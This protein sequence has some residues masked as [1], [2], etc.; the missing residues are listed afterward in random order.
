[1]HT[2]CK[3]AIWRIRC[4]HG[5]KRFR[6]QELFF[7]RNS[8]AANACRF[9]ARRTGDR[10]L[11]AGLRIVGRRGDELNGRRGNRKWLSTRSLGQS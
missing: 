1:M 10:P 8:Y 7:C 4:E 2:C 5:R 11:G 9:V 3:G 6:I